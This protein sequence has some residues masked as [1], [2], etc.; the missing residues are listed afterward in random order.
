MP[1]RQVG[2]SDERRGRRGG[3]RARSGGMVGMTL[4]YRRPS[5]RRHGFARIAVVCFVALGCKQTAPAPSPALGS[6]PSLPAEPATESVPTS[7]AGDKEPPDANVAAADS[8]APSAPAWQTALSSM[9]HSLGPTSSLLLRLTGQ[10]IEVVGVKD[11]LIVLEAASEVESLPESLWIVYEP[12]RARAGKTQR[13][14][15]Q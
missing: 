10:A 5:S 8:G 14:V 11:G 2:R 13:R 12:A 9:P 15:E 6:S 7:I 4:L 1:S 3:S